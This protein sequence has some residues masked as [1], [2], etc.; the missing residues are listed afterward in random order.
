M[1]V[2]NKAAFKAATWF[3]VT[4]GFILVLFKL[5]RGFIPGGLG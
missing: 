1:P 2:T 3:N 5:S 4:G